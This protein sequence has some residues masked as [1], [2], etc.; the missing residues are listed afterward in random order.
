LTRPVG[1]RV[2]LPRGLV[3]TAGY[4][5]LVVA[6]VSPEWADGAREYASGESCPFPALE[7]EFVLEVP[8]E[9]LLPGWRVTASLVGDSGDYIR[10][11]DYAQTGPGGFP[12]RLVGEF[13]LHRVGGPILVRR[14]KPGDRF[15]PLGM[16]TTKKLQD[17]MVDARIPRVWRDRIPIVCSAEHIIWVVGWR[18]DDRVRVTD[19][20][21]DVLRLE[22]VRRH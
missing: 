16:D 18:M 20:T 5:E 7:G 17:F 1:K 13:D 6:R 2:P 12:D 14:R 19:R 22:I 4:E 10:S 15:R 9:T 3:C 8:G 11:E 21:V